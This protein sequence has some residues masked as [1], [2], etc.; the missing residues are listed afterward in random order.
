MLWHS[1][2]HA[3]CVV[4][5]L[6]RCHKGW[7]HINQ[8]DSHLPH[9]ALTAVVFPGFYVFRRHVL[10]GSWLRK[11]CVIYPGGSFNLYAPLRPHQVFNTIL[12]LFI[13]PQIFIASESLVL[14]IINLELTRVATNE[15]LSLF[16]RK[17]RDT[18]CN[19]S[20]YGNKILGKLS[21]QTDPI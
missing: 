5:F 20:M 18:F 6:K 9:G 11:N 10:I 3:K 17:W 16:Y 12:T 8:Q 1:W 15:I 14:M 7:Q 21:K 2:S 4:R 13:N 19:F